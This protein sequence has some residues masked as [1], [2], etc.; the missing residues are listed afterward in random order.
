VDDEV[1]DRAVMN[2]KLLE[3]DVDAKLVKKY[4]IDGMKVWYL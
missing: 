3:D 2:L 1:R 4:I